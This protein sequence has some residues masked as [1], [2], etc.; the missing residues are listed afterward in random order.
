MDPIT[1]AELDS[2]SKTPLFLGI[3]AIL[4]AVTGLVL[5]WM[6]FSKAN[7]LEAQLLALSSPSEA[8]AAAEEKIDG[9]TGCLLYT[10]DAADE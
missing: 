7:D 8:L 6:G 1:S 9:N 10:S 4:L 3:A 2:P 5:A